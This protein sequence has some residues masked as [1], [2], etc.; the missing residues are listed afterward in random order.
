MLEIAQGSNSDALLI[1]LISDSVKKQTF[2]NLIINKLF[3]SQNFI[4]GH[5]S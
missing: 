2:V 5:F 3:Y 4:N 1:F